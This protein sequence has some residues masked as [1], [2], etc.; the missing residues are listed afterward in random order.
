MRF[1]KSHKRLVGIGGTVLALAITAAAVAYWTGSGSGSGTATVGTTSGTLELTATV[2]GE[3]TPGGEVPVEFEATNTGSTAVAVGAVSLERVESNKEGDCAT[4]D[5]TMDTVF[6]EGVIV[7]AHET[8][9]LPANGS[10]KYQ[11]TASNQDG[12]KGAVLTLH[13]SSGLS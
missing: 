12:C 11:D 6:E 13:I 5:F 3:V 10:L 4:E 8:Q 1:I 9:S 2:K 7:N